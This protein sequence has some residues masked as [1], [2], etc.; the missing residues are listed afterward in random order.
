MFL[1]WIV[2]VVNW[3]VWPV[4]TAAGT[5]LT[6]GAMC[7]TLET[8]TAGAATVNWGAVPVCIFP[9]LV[10]ATL[11]GTSFWS[12][13]GR[14]CL[15]GELPAL[16]AMCCL[17]AALNGCTWTNVHVILPAAPEFACPVVNAAPVRDKGVNL[18]GLPEMTTKGG[19]DCAP[20]VTVLGVAVVTEVPV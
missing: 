6:L 12:C 5:M 18:M 3:T 17:A 4:G 19:F 13:T 16:G 9:R 10:V 2:G 7:R 1:T 8:G 11:M 20:V 14:V 15:F